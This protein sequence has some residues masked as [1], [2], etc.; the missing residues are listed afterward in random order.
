MKTVA[1]NFDVSM[2]DILSLVKIVTDVLSL[3]KQEPSKLRS[4]QAFAAAAKKLHR[5]TVHSTR[6]DVV[7]YDGALLSACAEYELAVRA[8]IEKYIERAVM[9]C[10]KFDHLP[11][12]IRNWY[13]TGCAHLILNLT[14]DKFRH[15]TSEVITRSVA[16]T[17]KNVSGGLIV[18][19]YSNNERNFWPKQVEECLGI[20]LGIEKIWRKLSRETGLQGFV[21]TT[22]ESLA[23]ELARRRVT[24]FLERRNDI[25]HRGRSYYTASESEVQRHVT[26]M[27]TLINALADVMEK[28]LAAI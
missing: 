16:S 17:V 4:R 26:F 2:D 15:L 8:L 11:A 6:F 25:I 19:A 28:Q 13:P 18:E 5:T 23:E 24:E 21:G 22:N 9:K 27:K 3:A 7:A 12:S 14:Q 10:P 1:S 20:R